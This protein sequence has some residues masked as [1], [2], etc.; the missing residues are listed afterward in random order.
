MPKL[1]RSRF[2]L[3]C[4]GVLAVF[5]DWSTF[6]IAETP[7][8][9][10]ATLTVPKTVVDGNNLGFKISGLKPSEVVR[11]H[12]LRSLEKWRNDNGK[13]MRVRQALHA[14]VDFKASSSGTIDVDT[15]TPIRGTYQEPDSLAILRSGYRFGDPALKD[16]KVLDEALLAKEPADRVHLKLERDGQIAVEAGFRIV[17]SAPGLKFEEVKG[18]GWHAVYAWPVNQSNL[19]TVVSLHG[20]EGGSIGKA[21]GRAAQFASQGFAT[22]AMN[23]FAYPHEAIPGVPDKHLEIKIENLQAAR[24]WLSKRKEVDA[25]HFAVHGVSKG[26]EFSLVA[27]SHYPWITKVVAVVPSD[28]V[29]EGYAADAGRSTARSSWSIAGKPL[30]FVPLFSFDPNLDGLYRTNTERYDR[31]RQCF[32]D[33]ATAAR[34]P[35]EKTNAKMLLLA[36]D[37]DEVWSSG[38]MSRNIAEQ[39]VLANKQK[40]LA[41]KI[42]PTAGHQIAGTGTFPVRLYGE[43]SNDATSKD[44]VAEGTAAADAWRRTIKFLRE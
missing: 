34:I 8:S 22:L 19:R 5:V 24:D 38:S 15:A 42:Y 25:S 37:R 32:A 9:E 10:S 11:L 26:A 13:W 18:A 6:A 2:G 4:L 43:Q 7:Q 27:A 44:I 16:V 21:R 29:W 39:L 12:A 17:D 35:I 41:L 3:F 14:F 20:S 36:S 40:Q 1:I 33:Q 23:Y 28:I 30:P 31:S